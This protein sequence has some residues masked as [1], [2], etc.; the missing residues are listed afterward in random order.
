MVLDVRVHLR[1]EGAMSARDDPPGNPIAW[2]V[3]LAQRLRSGNARQLRELVGMTRQDLTNQL[4][5]DY[6]SVWRWETGRGVPR[7]IGV[8]LRWLVILVEME[9]ALSHAGIGPEI[10][11]HNQTPTTEQADATSLPD[12]SAEGTGDPSQR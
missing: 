9:A 4:G 6:S 10:L 8:I 2:R 1:G 11:Q 7:D 5:A 12:Q 3:Q